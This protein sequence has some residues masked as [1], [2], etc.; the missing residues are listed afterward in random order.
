[1]ISLFFLSTIFTN[2]KQKFAFLLHSVRSIQKN[3]KKNEKLR[4]NVNKCEYKWRQ[5][6]CHTDTN[7]H[8]GWKVVT[9]TSALDVCL[10]AMNKGHNYNGRVW[11]WSVVQCGIPRC[12]HLFIHSTEFV[13]ICIKSVEYDDE[14]MNC[15]CQNRN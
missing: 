5:K 15:L 14:V 7:T 10:N 8:T 2:T 13:D 3:T 6:I 1:M 11:F 12:L 4:K 9:L